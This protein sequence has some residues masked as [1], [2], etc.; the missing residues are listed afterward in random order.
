MLGVGGG[1][2]ITP[3]LAL[4]TDLPQQSVLGTSL[5]SMVAPA[6]SGSYVQMQRGLLAP[7]LVVPLSVGCVAGGVLSSRVALSARQDHLRLLFSG[8]LSGLALRMLV[9]A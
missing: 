1:I 2:V 7:R 4:T 9:K 8:A 3:L 5:L 6:V